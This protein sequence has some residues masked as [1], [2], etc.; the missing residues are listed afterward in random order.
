MKRS[1]TNYATIL[2][3]AKVT[4]SDMS[5]NK[6]QRLDYWSCF[7]LL[8]LVTKSNKSRLTF[9]SWLREA[10][11]K[12]VCLVFQFRKKKIM[13][14]PFTW[15]VWI[16]RN[17]WTLL[18]CITEICVKLIRSICLS[19]S[20]TKKKTVSKPTLFGSLWLYLKFFEVLHVIVNWKT[21]LIGQN[22]TKKMH[23]AIMILQ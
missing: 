21:K 8:K 10:L 13:L 12:S 9:L 20:K 1:L 15:K 18:F 23:T 5:P 17:F 19:K 6:F 22:Q 16:E 7:L 11:G 2:R 4:H 14:A 3:F